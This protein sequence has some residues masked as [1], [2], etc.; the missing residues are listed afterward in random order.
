MW[1]MFM[2]LI[3]IQ[4]IIGMTSEELHYS[5]INIPHSAV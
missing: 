3:H 2:I 1:P 4:S 5:E